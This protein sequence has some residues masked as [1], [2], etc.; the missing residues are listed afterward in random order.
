MTATSKQTASKK[1]AKAS[2]STKK[3]AP[4]KAAPK[5]AAAPATPTPAPT[6][7]PVVETNEVQQAEPV[8]T[9]ESSMTE[10]LTTFSD[11]IQ[12]LT[13]ALNKVKADYKVLEKAVLKEA[14]VMDKANAK[15]NKNKGT[16]APSGFVKPAAISAELA[17]FLSVPADTKMARTDVTKM[18]TAYVK[19]HKLQDSTNGRKINPDAKLKALLKVTDKDEVTYFNLQKYMKPH[20]VKA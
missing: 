10:V 9:I 1:S 3:S 16:R 7:A 4:K 8:Q 19:D 2:T 17:K 14:K 5:A 12:T 18:I 20:F 6:P 11:T 15:R 13:A